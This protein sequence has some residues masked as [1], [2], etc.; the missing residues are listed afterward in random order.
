MASKVR[1]V[2]FVGS[3]GSVPKENVVFHLGCMDSIRGRENT[4]S[5]AD[6]NQRRSIERVTI[7]AVKRHHGLS[8]VVPMAGIKPIASKRSN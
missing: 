3:N 5:G 7:P 1:S 8:V 6:R 2:V 4:L